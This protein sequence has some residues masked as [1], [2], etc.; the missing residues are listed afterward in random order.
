MDEAATLRVER[1]LLEFRLVML[2]LAI[3]SQ[4]QEGLEALQLAERMTEVFAQLRPV[5]AK[6]AELR[7]PAAST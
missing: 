6:L 2:E 3:E 4:R 5:N 7:G 1:D